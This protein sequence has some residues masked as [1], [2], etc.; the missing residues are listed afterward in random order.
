MRVVVRDVVCFYACINRAHEVPVSW[1]LR[2]G[3]GLLLGWL[4][5][6][7]LE[8]EFPD[9]HNQFASIITPSLQNRSMRTGRQA[10]LSSHWREGLYFQLCPA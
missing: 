6:R 1:L 7:G 10:L 2:L 9:I 5:L 3:L 4:V 8:G